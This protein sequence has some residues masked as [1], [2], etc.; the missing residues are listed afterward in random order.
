MLL[1]PQIFL[2]NGKVLLPENSATNMITEDPMQTAK[3]LKDAGTDNIYF[4]DLSITPVGESPNFLTIKQIHE[5]E[6]IGTYV[7]GNFKT[8]KEVE[9]YVQGGAQLVALGSIA[10]QKPDFLKEVC[11]KLPARVAA[12]IDVKGGKVTIPGYA[13]ASNK[14]PLDYADYFNKNGVRYIFYSD[15]ETD[16][17]LSDKNIE[18]IE[19]FCR[20]I[21]ARIICTSEVQNLSD[22]EKIANIDHPRLEGLIVSKSIYEGKI[23]LKGATALINDIT[24]TTSSESTLTEM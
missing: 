3:M 24:L 13:V 14:S 21:T 1:I 11:D 15:M 7:G 6:K 19:R 16:G 8:S 10:Y 9:G 4:V 2:K 23:D 18:N 12:K 22:V 5:S 17:T 20:E